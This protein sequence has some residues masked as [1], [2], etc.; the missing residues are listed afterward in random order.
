MYKEYRPSSILA[1]HINVIWEYKGD[2]KREITLK[3]PPYGCTDFVFVIRG[4]VNY[5]K[6]NLTMLSSHSYFNGPMNRYTE[7]STFTGAIHILGIRIFP[8]S[9]H[10]FMNIPL[11]EL[12]NFRCS[13]ADITPVFNTLIFDKELYRDDIRPLI[14]QIEQ[15]L[16]NQLKRDHTINNQAVK[17]AIQ[18]IH[19]C[20]G[21]LSIQDL[22]TNIYL[23]QRQFE[24]KF[25]TYTGYSAKEYSRVVK[26]WNTVHL[27]KNYK[28]DNLLS[29]A[30]KAG[31][32]DAAHLS[33]EIKQL[34]GN[35]P[36]YFSEKQ[37]EQFATH[38]Y[39]EP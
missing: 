29:I 37:E 28:F 7:L 33:K 4:H 14:I 8:G 22:I 32:Y 16:I 11:N 1:P 24:R 18:E 12:R 2:A 35:S 13:T 6:S 25:K 26:F 39:L 10:H 30:V 27:L 3:I 31:Y 19:R 21:N 9:L 20:K 5:P 23:S 38:L 15:L 34:S 17:Y 36:S